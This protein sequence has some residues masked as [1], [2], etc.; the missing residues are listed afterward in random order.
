MY[1]VLTSG[2]EIGGCPGKAYVDVPVWAS[3][4]GGSSAGT[5]VAATESDSLG[6]YELELAPGAYDLCVG[7]YNFYCTRVQIRARTLDRYDVVDDRWT[8]ATCAP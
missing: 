2:C 1:G 8:A 3:L 7:R 6:F 4:L 5:R